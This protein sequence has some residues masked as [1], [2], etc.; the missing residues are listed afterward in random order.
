[1]N[2]KTSFPASQS[3]PAPIAEVTVYTN[4]ALVTRRGMVSLTG[5]ERELI[6]SELP[7]TLQTD[8]VR[9]KVS[10]SVPVKLLGV[11]TEKAF[12]SETFAKRVVQ[13]SQQIRQLEE[14]QRHLRDLLTSFGLQRDFVR[15][16]SEKSVERYSGLNSPEKISLNEIKEFLDFLGQQHGEYAKTIAQ[17]E[18][19]QQ[20]ID[21]QL[22]AL[23]QQRQQMV[24][25]AYKDTL[26][27]YK[28]VVTVE[29]ANALDF[30][31]EISYLVNRAIWTPVYDLRTSST[32]KRVNL[33]YLAEVRQ[34]TGEDWMGVAVKLSTAKPAL[35]T[36]PP[37]LK[38][39]YIDSLDGSPAPAPDLREDT[40]FSELEA[41][42]ADETD[43]VNKQ[44]VL[45]TQ[46]VVSSSGS[47]VTFCVDGAC[48]IPADAA[49]HKV[50]IFSQD[51]PCRTEYVAVPRL[52]SFAYLEATVKNNLLGATLLP[53][54]AN[55]FRDNTL[56]GT[57]QL[58][59]VAPGAEFK[60]NLGVDEG[61]KVEREL[62]EREVELMGNYRRTTY[63]Y[64]LVVTNLRDRA[65]TIRVIEQLPVSRNEQIKVHLKS[66][67]PPIGLGQMGQLEWLL[68]LQRQSRGKHKRELY[69]QFTVE[70]PADLT[71]VS[72][73]I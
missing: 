31:L 50:V 62:V 51:Y 1:M 46:K 9:A 21:R 20:E 16:L 25:P 30:E 29:S 73:D 22:E 63:G 61:L 66:T 4:Q 6:V 18:R 72:L 8:S 48:N 15:G 33:R 43:A 53:G 60:L 54:K 17:R 57:T 23:R 68:A 24:Q 19:E 34:K 67:N 39:W 55:I 38:P 71:V 10:G 26:S 58:E 13:I 70:H 42:L 7:L 36:M 65:T 32:S 27:S 2:P 5:S 35:T 56:V 47:V 52:F 49:A 12:A 3:I 11:R 59:K 44:N 41:L 40:D 69:Y 64:R 37:K 28:I 14:Q 45:E